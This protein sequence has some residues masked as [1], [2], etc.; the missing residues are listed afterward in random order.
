MEMQP[1]KVEIIQDNHTT[2]QNTKQH[3]LYYS[4]CHSVN[5]NTHTQ[6]THNNNTNNTN[7]SNNR[8]NLKQSKTSL[9]CC[10]G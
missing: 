1:F 9:I 6:H 4:H 5:Y 10:M 3:K 2:L 7:S 8:S